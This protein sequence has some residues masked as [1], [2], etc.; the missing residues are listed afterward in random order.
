MVAP[1][2]QQL[3]ELVDRLSDQDVAETLAYIRW[4]ID[5]GIPPVTTETAPIDDE[6]ESEEE[7]VAVARALAQ[8]ERGDV[9]PHAQ[10]RRELGL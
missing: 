10:V 6:E 7:R 9:I 5:D 1:L 3:H 4:L 8:L 2:K